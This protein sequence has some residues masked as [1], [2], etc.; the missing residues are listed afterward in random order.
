MGA[1]DLEVNMVV[2]L[3]PELERAVNELARRQGLSPEALIRDALRARFLMPA[4]VDEPR[5]AWEERLRGVAT[6]C[7]VSL[8]DEVLGREGIYE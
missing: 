8:P 3:D 2:T 7:G 5:D 1:D 4:P 6:D